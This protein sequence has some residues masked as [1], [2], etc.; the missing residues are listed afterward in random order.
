MAGAA[1]TKG[2]HDFGNGCYGYLQPD[3]GWGLSNAGLVADSGETL[4]VDTLMDLAL[5]REMLASMRAAVPAAARIGTVI[6]THS[7]PDHTFGN[8]L[9]AGAA[10][11]SSDVCLE[12]KRAQGQR[13]EEHT[14]EL[15]SHHDIVC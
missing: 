10:I 8:E 9:V 11:I 1:F 6:N 5:T 2:L 3:G 7:N 15:Q 4:L 14:S 12:E 13:S